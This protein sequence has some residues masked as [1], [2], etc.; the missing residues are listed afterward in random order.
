MTLQVLK[1]LKK[2]VSIKFMIHRELGGWQPPRP[3]GTIHASEV[4]KEGFCPREWAFLDMGLAKKRDEF[5]GTAMAI[6]FAHGRDMEYRLRN[7]WLRKSM[8]GLWECGVCLSEHP[9]WGKQPFG[10]CSK[11]GYSHQWRYKETRLESK[12]SGVSGGIDG[13]VDVGEKKARILEIKSIDKDQFKSLQA[14]LA[15][16]K[17]RTSLYLRLAHE[18]LLVEAERIN[19]ARATILYVSK[20]FGFKDD[21]LKE[22]GIADSPFSPFKEFVVERDDSL[23][24]NP[25]RLAKVLTTWRNLPSE[26]RYNMPCG[27]CSSGLIKRAQQCSAVSPCWSGNYPGKITWLESGSPKHPGKPVVIT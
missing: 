2:P 11:C 1:S 5:I 22:A 18:A 17:L 27:V 3:H 24:D 4:L 23:T 10:A 7:E 13:F 15:D 9:V 20:S 25:L 8:V 26:E 6:T 16:H 14:P 21:T 19:T 12:V